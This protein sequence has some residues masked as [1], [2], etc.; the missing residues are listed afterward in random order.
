MAGG[1]EQQQGGGDDGDEPDE[2]GDD[3]GHRGAPVEL[4]DEWLRVTTASVVLFVVLLGVGLVARNASATRSAS[5][6]G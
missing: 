6:A 2:D 5:S 3:G 1:P 4:D